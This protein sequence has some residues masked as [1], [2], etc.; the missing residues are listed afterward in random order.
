MYRVIFL[1]ILGLFVAQCGT[2]SSSNERS[3]APEPSSAEQTEEANPKTDDTEAPPKEY[4][5]AVF[6]RRIQLLGSPDSGLN[7][8]FLK[9][10]GANLKKGFGLGESFLLCKD[11]AT[12]PSA[13][14]DSLKQQ[15]IVEKVQK[16]F[17]DIGV[18]LNVTDQLPNAGNFTT[19]LV[20]GDLGDLG[21]LTKNLFGK[22]PL[23]KGNINL[24]DIGFVF[25]D[26]IGDDLGKLVNAIGNQA[27]HTFGLED[28]VSGGGVMSDKISDLFDGFG[29]GTTAD[30][31]WQDSIKILLD[32]LGGSKGLADVLDGIPG[33]DE[34][35][36]L[37][38]F[39]GIAQM[40]LSG[41]FRSGGLDL[42]ELWPIVVAIYPQLSVYASL[43]ELVGSGDLPKFSEIGGLDGIIELLNALGLADLLVKGDH[44]LPIDLGNVASLKDLFSAL[45][46]GDL[47][48]VFR[49][50]GFLDF[51]GDL[52][53]GDFAGVWDYLKNMIEDWFSGSSLSLSARQVAGLDVAGILDLGKVENLDQ[54]LALLSHHE[55]HINENYT[56]AAR[57]Q[58]LTLLKVAYGQA[59]QGL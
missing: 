51:V 52:L 48:S 10:D 15:E 29:S 8:L 3:S 44:D 11:E 18:N 6:T 43:V 16:L 23:D 24:N 39:E 49:G 7:S 13:G 58:L 30:G 31:K 57:V 17:D 41:D 34:L 25:S 40:L 2:K 33:L 27:G 4:Y 12:I 42:K 9:F 46:K 28:L 45:V 20:G 47:E 19:L 5:D 35:S 55:A 50:G 38:Q 26:F 37:S 36:G 22:S 1:M 21:C 53:N 59:Y 14:F 54:L 32:V 56:G